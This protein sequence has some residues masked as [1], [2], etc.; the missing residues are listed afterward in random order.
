MIWLMIFQSLYFMLPAYVANMTPVFFRKVP[1]LDYPLDFKLKLNNQPL[2]GK[3]KTFRG[4]FFG[5][6][7][8]IVTAYIQ[9]LFFPSKLSVADYFNWLLLGFLL[10]FGALLGDAVKSFF[11]RRLGVRPGQRFLPWD[12]IDHAIGA[13]VFGSFVFMP[14]LAMIVTIIVA[15]CV[16]QI[17]AAHLGFYLGI[18]GEKW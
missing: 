3:N 9:Y 11:K 7:F 15:S 1:F 6:L 17:L 16:F 8:A 2:L 14:S 18:R 13:L 4:L 5:V 10:G 12:Q